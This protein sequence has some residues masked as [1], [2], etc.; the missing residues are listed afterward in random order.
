MPKSGTFV[1][2]LELQEK[3]SRKLPAAK[4]PK[5]VHLHMNYIAGKVRDTVKMLVRIYHCLKISKEMINAQCK[6]TQ[7][8]SDAWWQT[9]GA[10]KLMSCCFCRILPCF[11][12]IYHH[13][14]LPSSSL[15]CEHFYA[16]Q[17][18]SEWH[19]T[20]A[21]IWSKR[22]TIDLL[23]WWEGVFL[24]RVG[25][26]PTPPID[27]IKLGRVLIVQTRIPIKLVSFNL[28]CH[29]NP[30]LGPKSQNFGMFGVST[31]CSTEHL[32]PC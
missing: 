22:L 23:R 24:L 5:C 31:I 8:G 28:V 9:K 26:H 2:F 10:A 25:L 4:G 3:F 30:L 16:A 14:A 17:K 18:L 13:V 32:F 1:N 12:F 27:P 21:I 19:K 15:H 29:G 20:I 7:C 6:K 11:T